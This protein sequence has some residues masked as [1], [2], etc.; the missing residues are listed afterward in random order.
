MHRSSAETAAQLFADG[1]RIVSRAHRIASRCP[2][3]ADPNELLRTAGGNPH[4][5]GEDAR[6]MF[7]RCYSTEKFTVSDAVMRELVRLAHEADERERVAW[8]ARLDLARVPGPRWSA[9]IEGVVVARGRSKDTAR[10]KALDR[11]RGLGLKSDAA[12]SLLAARL[13]HSTEKEAGR[14]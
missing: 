3:D 13:G 2:P 6:E 7:R 9:E 11:L 1:Y 12:A 14:A 8:R 5:H 10:D 4:L